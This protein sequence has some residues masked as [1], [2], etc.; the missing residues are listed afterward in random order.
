M[1]YDN[2]VE[3]HK[4]MQVQHSGIYIAAATLDIPIDWICRNMGD[5]PVCESMQATIIIWWNNASW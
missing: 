2:F 3:A 1:M 5:F 4:W